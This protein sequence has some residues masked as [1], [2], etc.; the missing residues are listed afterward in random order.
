MRTFRIIFVSAVLVTSAAFA[1]SS[2]AQNTPSGGGGGGQ[3][4]G[5]K[6]G[7]GKGEIKMP[8]PA[9]RTEVPAHPVDLMLGRPTKNA[10][11]LS[12]LTYADTEGHVAYGTQ[13]GKLTSETPGCWANG[14][15]ASSGTERCRSLSCCGLPCQAMPTLKPLRGTNSRAHLSISS[16]RARRYGILAGMLESVVRRMP[17][18]LKRGA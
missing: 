14:P 16:G 3:R 7:Q 8:T 11:T 10:V 15:K 5:G 1:I 6:G 18:R 2:R 13:P 17:G 4:E 12:V 9:F